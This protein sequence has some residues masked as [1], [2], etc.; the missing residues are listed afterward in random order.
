MKLMQK[1]MRILAPTCERQRMEFR[2][3]L[4]KVNAHTEDLLRTMRFA[5]EQVTWKPSSVTKKT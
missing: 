2:Q 4:A 5:P 3:E 1:V